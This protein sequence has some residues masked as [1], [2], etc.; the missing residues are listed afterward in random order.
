MGDVACV[1]S[2]MS[3]HPLSYSSLTF[4]APVCHDCAVPMLTVTTI[5]H[6]GTPNVVRIIS[7]QCE[8]CGL[9]LGTPRPRDRR[10]HVVLQ[11]S[12]FMHPA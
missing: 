9:T 6:H 12:D 7:Y 11:F 3:I 8:K 2:G 1:L 10:K 5:F 4:P